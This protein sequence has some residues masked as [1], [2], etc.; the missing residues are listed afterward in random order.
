MYKGVLHPVFLAF[1]KE[2][3]EII[4]RILGGITFL[5][6]SAHVKGL[7]V[8]GHLATKC[9]LGSCALFQC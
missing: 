4:D 8:I 9:C 3:G 5:A 6:H 7:K 2:H 1:T